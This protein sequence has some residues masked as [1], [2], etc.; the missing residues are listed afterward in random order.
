[1]NYEING[2]IRESVARLTAIKP[3]NLAANATEL[4]TLWKALRKEINARN[5]ALSALESSDPAY[6]AGAGTVVALLQLSQ[7]VGD[8]L[9]ELDK[10][11]RTAN[12]VIIRVLKKAPRE[13][14]FTFGEAQPT[15]PAA[16]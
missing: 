11:A 2:E 4:G 10:L 14:G 13:Q 15:E 6:A 5:D 8:A 3:A 12:K 16:N 9:V 1:M 7:A